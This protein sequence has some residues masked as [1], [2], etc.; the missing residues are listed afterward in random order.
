MVWAI[1]AFCALLLAPEPEIATAR[2]GGSAQP[3]DRKTFRLVDILPR[4]S[5]Y[6]SS[7]AMMA[8]PTLISSTPASIAAI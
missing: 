7:F 8:I 5:D 1:F 4:P 2:A 3:E 6:I